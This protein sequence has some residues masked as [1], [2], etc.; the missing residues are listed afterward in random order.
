MAEILKDKNAKLAFTAGLLHDIGKVLLGRFIDKETIPAMEKA[1]NDGKSSTEAEHIAMGIDHAELG[2]MLLR[3]WNIPDNLV[4]AVR[5]HH[6]PLRDGTK[7]TFVS[8]IINT[9]DALCIASEIGIIT[10]RRFKPLP[11]PLVCSRLNLNAEMQDEIVVRT[12]S[13]LDN[14]KD[15]F[16]KRD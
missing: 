6:T 5:W 15:V 1:L 12:K 9:S 3:D 10:P 16:S 13:S 8:G 11:D 4:Q 14:I 2:S 7:D